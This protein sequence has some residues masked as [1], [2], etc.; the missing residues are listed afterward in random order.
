MRIGILTFHRAD[1]YGAVLQCY[2]LQE[3][4]KRLGYQVYVLDYRQ[5]YIE[6]M[7]HRSKFRLMASQLLRSKTI[8]FSGNMQKGVVNKKF[9]FFRESFFDVHPSSFSDISKMPKDLD[10]YIVGSDQVWSYSVCGD[11]ADSIYYGDFKKLTKGKVISYA[12]SGSIK[13]FGSWSSYELEKKLKNFD[14]ISVREESLKEHL[15]DYTDTPISVN[16]DPTLLIDAEQWN[17]VADSSAL[18]L[19]KEYILLYSVRNFNGYNEILEQKARTI[20]ESKR[21]PLIILGSMSVYGPNDFIKLIKNASFFITSSFHGT[22]FA[23]IFRKDYATIVYD[24]GLDDR[25]V[26]LLNSIGMNHCLYSIED[27]LEIKKVEYYDMDNKLKALREKAIDYI[28]K[29]L[30]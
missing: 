17:K 9:E 13:T 7:Y 28:L 10:A 16:I 29:A 8:D 25:Y 11:C 24:D 30:N 14:S 23:N 4:L 3:F 1:N 27:R 5:S 21:I 12:A 15:K 2:A 26:N 6:F 20:S 22:V 18:D 19:P